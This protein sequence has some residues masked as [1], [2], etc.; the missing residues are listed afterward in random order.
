MIVDGRIGFIGGLNICDD[1]APKIDGGMG[2][3]DTHLR[4]EGAVVAKSL[5]SLF[6]ETWV[7]ADV[8][9][10]LKR[11]GGESSAGAGI[12][13]DGLTPPTPPFQG[14]EKFASVA[15]QV[16]GNKEFLQRVRLRRAYVHAIR[17]AQRYILIE[18]AYFIPDR[19]IRRALYQAV[20]R[21]VVVAAVVAMYSDVKVAALA[22]RSLYSELI[23]GGVRLFEYPISMMHSKVAVVDDCWS[24]VASYNLDHRSLMHN[25][26]AGVMAVDWR[27]AAALRERILADIELSREVTREFH[28]ARP[29]DHVLMEALAY[30]VRYWL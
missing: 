25:L 22:S 21:G 18:N 16:L 1:N 10:L 30:Q 7:L 13:K 9:P 23:T 19:G 15:V 29:W 12:T 2:W 4:I 3:R 26:E 20:Q 5:R 27:V 17:R 11:E 28:D 24:M 8:L 14:G 6:E